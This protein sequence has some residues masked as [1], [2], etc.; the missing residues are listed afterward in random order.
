MALKRIVD[1][2]FWTDEKVMEEFSPEDKLFML[3]LLT[4]PHVTLL[5]VY[6]ISKK[7]MA[8]ELGYS[9]DTINVLLDRFENT[10]K[11]IKYDD[12][13]REIAILNFLKYNIIK[14]GKPIEDCLNKEFNEVKNKELVVLVIN[15][16]KDYSISNLTISN[17]LNKINGKEYG[18]GNGNG[19]GYGNGYGYGY[20]YGDTSTYRGTYRENPL[21]TEE[22][23]FEEPSDK[24][25]IQKKCIDGIPLVYQEENKGGQKVKNFPPEIVFPDEDLPF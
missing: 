1:T 17:F 25:C 20:G 9:I 21:K 24:K 7:Q 10:Y 8:F 23:D 22:N 16:L 19:K 12:N 18:K 6:Q 13:T 15:H 11:I 4:N 3:Y 2:R 5:G 14:G